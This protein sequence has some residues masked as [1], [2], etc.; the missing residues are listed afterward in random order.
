[1]ICKNLVKKLNGKIRCK[2]I[3]QDITLDWCRKCLN[4]EPRQ[5]KPIKKIGKDK[6]YVFEEVYDYVLQRDKFKCVLCDSTKN[7]HLHHIDGRSK[8]LTNDVRN[9]VMLCQNC[10]L[11]VVHKNQKKYRPILKNYIR[12]IEDNE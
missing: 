6:V 5:S 2:K 10:H 1:M 8:L 3:R 9:C 4:F 11:N 12:R 7:L